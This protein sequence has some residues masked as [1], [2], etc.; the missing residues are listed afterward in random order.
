MNRQASVIII[1]GCAAALVG[2]ACGAFGAHALRSRIAPELLATWQ[3]GVTYHF[4]HALGMLAVGLASQIMGHSRM[5]NWAGALM[6]GG[7]LLFS[8]S[9][10]LLALTG[11]GA[12][13][14]VTPLGGLAWMA[15]WGLFA[16]AVWRARQGIL[17]KQSPL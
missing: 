14:A 11:S 7:L 17:Q 12:F 15:A 5:L 2:V 10:Y 3:T 13:G 6:F 4:Y 8:G 16:A 1:A 9:L